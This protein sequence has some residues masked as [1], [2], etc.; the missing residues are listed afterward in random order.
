MFGDEF[1]KKLGNLKYFLVR[2]NTSYI[3]VLVIVSLQTK[4][5]DCLFSNFVRDIFSHIFLC[6][7]YTHVKPICN[8]VV[9]IIYSVVS[10]QCSH[11]ITVFEHVS[12]KCCGSHIVAVSVC[13]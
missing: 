10:G 9:H 1:Q 11:T 4:C 12:M 8:A 3:S 2:K 7:L 6:S 13:L 5:H